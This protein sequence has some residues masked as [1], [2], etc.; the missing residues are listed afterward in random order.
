MKLNN[1]DLNLFVVFDT[2]YREKNLTRASESL[3]ITQP[4]VSN[5][6]RRLR[7]LF[8]DQLF[9][10]QDG[11]MIPTATAKSLADRVQNALVALDESLYEL[12]SFDYETSTRTFRL[13]MNDDAE[14]SL[15]P[16]LMEFLQNRAPG[17]SVESYSIPRRD[18]A[19]EF[20]TGQLDF[21]FDAP[22]ISVPNLLHRYLTEDTYICATR[23][24]PPSVT[25][26]AISLEDYTALPHAHVS[27]RRKGQGHIDLHLN[28]QGLTRNIR[29]RT[30]NSHTAVAIAE[31]TDMLLTLPRRVAEGQSLAVVDLPF[32]VP[33]LEWHVY[34]A[35]ICE[36][37]KGHQWMK[38][39]I[40]DLFQLK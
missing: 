7:E 34:W 2:I 39:T 17:I 10:R 29:I 19:R 32:N 20:S 37:D 12:D 24:G 15:L 25:Q 23:K 3:N 22:L 27:S 14:S 28:R 36:Y 21:A 5:S 1:V 18:L 4:A 33:N 26:K 40:F 31:K 6:L 16:Y 11:K 9:V 35:K 38:K 8:N 13:A 30:P